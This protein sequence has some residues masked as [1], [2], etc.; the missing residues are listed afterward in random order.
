MNERSFS[1]IEKEKAILAKV[2]HL[3]QIQQAQK[4]EKIKSIRSNM[5]ANAGLSDIRIPRLSK[6]GVSSNLQAK[7][8][9][10]D[11]S[12]KNNLTMNEDVVNPILIEKES[13]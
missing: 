4:I 7:K 9:L 11:I 8:N 10:L 3:P 13:P 12:Q 2:I 6:V 1:E 5:Q